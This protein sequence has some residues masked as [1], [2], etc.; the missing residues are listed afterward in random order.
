MNPAPKDLKKNGK[1]FRDALCLKTSPDW[2]KAEAAFGGDVSNIPEKD[3]IDSLYSAIYSKSI[4][5]ERLTYF[6]Q[7]LERPEYKETRDALLAI[8]LA[9]QTPEL[10]AVLERKGGDL[11]SAAAYAFKRFSGGNISSIAL[12]VARAEN[13]ALKESFAEAG[14]KIAALEEITRSLTARL[15]ALEAPATESI[16][17]PR[18]RPPHAAP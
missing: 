11:G 7:G 6:C 12:Q 10:Q 2:A 13:A 18:R 8:A 17:K 5:A 15:E 3:Y 16:D 4:S 1:E 9:A 14:K